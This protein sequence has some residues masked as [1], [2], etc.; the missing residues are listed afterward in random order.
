MGVDLAINRVYNIPAVSVDTTAGGTFLVTTAQ[1]EAA[2]KG[3]VCVVILPS[4]DIALV[5]GG[6]DG[7]YANSPFMCPAGI[8]TVQLWSG[9][10]LKAISSS[11][12]STVKVGLGLR[13]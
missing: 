11:G 1:L 7:T 12:T 2:P 3:I 9:G 6:S 4:V 10:P 8:P 13:Q 5:D